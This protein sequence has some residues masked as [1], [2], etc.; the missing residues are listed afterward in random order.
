MNGGYRGLAV[1]LEARMCASGAEKSVKRIEQLLLQN[2]P[3]KHNLL[4]II[5]T[6]SL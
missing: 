3:S 2:N 4:S 1:L 5:F 6:E